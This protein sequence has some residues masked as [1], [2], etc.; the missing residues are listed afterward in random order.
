MKATDI[1]LCEHA[2]LRRMFDVIEHEMR[3]G[4]TSCDVAAFARLVE[5]MLCEHAETEDELLFSPLDSL[6]KEKGR[7]RQ[8]HFNQQENALLLKRSQSTTPV[9]K[10]KI[11]LLLA[12]R[13]QRNHFH[14]EERTVFPLAEVTFQPEALEKLG[15]QWAQRHPHLQ[16]EAA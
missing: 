8:L 10:A 5:N 9:A 12:F 7:F 15:Q 4:E 11:L 2:V 3:D 13:I 1:L 14:D 16:A 6:L